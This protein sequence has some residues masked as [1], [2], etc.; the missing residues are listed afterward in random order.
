VCTTMGWKHGAISNQ[1]YRPEARLQ[2]L[3]LT[4]SC[5]VLSIVIQVAVAAPE[6]LLSRQVKSMQST[7]QLALSCNEAVFASQRFYRTV[8]VGGIVEHKVLRFMR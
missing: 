7:T 3:T 1:L 4:Y 8:V 6:H 2:R 5:V